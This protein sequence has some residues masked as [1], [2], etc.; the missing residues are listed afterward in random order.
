MA[1]SGLVRQLACTT[2]GRTPFRLR[3]QN[4]TSSPSS[5]KGAMAP[6]AWPGRSPAA[7]RGRSVTP[8][9]GRSRT[10]PRCKASP[11]RRGW[12][13]PVPLTTSTSGRV[14]RERTAF[15]SNVPSRSAR[16]PGRY[17]P[18]ASPVASAAASSRR[19]RVRAAAAHAGSRPTPPGC[20]PKQMKQPAADA[21][22]PR[23][24]QSE[25]A[26]VPS[27]FWTSTRPSA[28]SGHAPTKRTL[29]ACGRDTCACSGSKSHLHR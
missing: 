24:H 12:S 25:G 19:P 13:R 17:R 16:K 15:S 22:R 26:A 5:R 10:A 14:G 8:T 27:T 9:V 29:H 4:A 28:V 23:G 6:L 2:M 11:A 7:S 1:T 3:S 18:P 20:G 21:M